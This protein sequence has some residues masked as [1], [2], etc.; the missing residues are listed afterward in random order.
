MLRISNLVTGYG[1]DPVLRG[2]TFDVPDA[3]VTAVFGH[4]GAGKSS[5]V[6]SLVGLLPAWKGSL[7][8]DGVELA[9]ASSRT[10]VESGIVASFQDQSVFPTMTVAQNLHLG[11][12]VRWRDRAFVADRTE[13]MM[14]LFPR[15]AER[16]YQLAYTL[17]GGERRMLSIGMALVTD[18]KVVILDEPST[19][20]SPAVTEFVFDTVASIRDKLGK[21]IILVEQNVQHALS[22]ADKAVVLKTGSVTFDGSPKELQDDPDLVMM[23]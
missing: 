11:A 18:P 12:H 1:K 21:S 8:L 16:A 17:S 2:V 4:N 19:G 9:T 23:F 5:L 22:F 10:R 14:A 6:R 7:S 15:L 3:S 20:L 13:K